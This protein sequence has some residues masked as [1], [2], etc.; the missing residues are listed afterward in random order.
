MTFFD[1]VLA[2][3]WKDVRSELRA[4][5][6]MTTMLIFGLL[7]VVIFS[8]AFNPMERDVKPV[9]PGLIWVAYFFAGVLGLNRSF[10]SE[11]SH[12]A[13]HGL[14]LTPVDRS[15]IYFGKMVG[16]LLF[17][18]AVEAVLTPVLFVLLN[19]P[20]RGEPGYFLV[21]LFLSTLGFIAAGTFLSALAANT[22]FSEVLL[23]ILLFPLLS[24][25]VIAAV[26]ATAGI[27]EQNPAQVG[28]WLEMLV[29]FD[30]VFLAVPLILFEYL[31]EV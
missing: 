24:P 5:E 9:F 30:L 20:W 1:R 17:M 23:P 15:V 13:L 6:M 3:V 10:V 27:L 22:R 21:T 14:M 8:F 31:L 7:V 25:L 18:L 16:N 12:G 26:R 19:Y 2:V 29:V 28:L 4:K 11:G